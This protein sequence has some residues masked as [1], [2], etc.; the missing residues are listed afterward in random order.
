MLVK[1]VMSTDVVTVP[2]SGTL[3]EA[4]ERLLAED[5]GSVIVQSEDGNPVGI[6]TESDVLRALFRTGNPLADVDVA[7]LTHRPLVTTKPT[8]TVP[9][10]ASRMAAKDVKK[11]PV[12]DDLDLVGIVTMTDI[13]RHIPGIR[14]EATE[15]GES[16]QRWTPE[17]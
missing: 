14:R 8:T 11:A 5:V 17:P 9:Y 10:V 12:M 7:D 1:D 13:V 4:V 15:H 2:A 3:R 6:V 16:Q